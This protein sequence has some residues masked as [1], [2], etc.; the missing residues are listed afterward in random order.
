MWID[1]IVAQSL[2][3]SATKQGQESICRFSVKVFE[4]PEGADKLS[5]PNYNEPGF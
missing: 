3:L 5:A 4:L 2:A 1:L